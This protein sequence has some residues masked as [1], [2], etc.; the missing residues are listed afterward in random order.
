MLSVR[1]CGAWVFSRT[2]DEAAGRSVFTAHC[3]ASF[4]SRLMMRDA[5]V[6]PSAGS[7]SKT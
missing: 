3:T 2:S 5:P 1:A 7:S 4:S 6:R